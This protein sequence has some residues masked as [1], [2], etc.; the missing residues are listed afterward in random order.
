MEQGLQQSFGSNCF[1]FL[2]TFR[3]RAPADGIFLQLVVLARSALWVYQSFV[4]KNSCL[5]LLDTQLIR[6]SRL[7]KNNAVVGLKKN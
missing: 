1:L 5:L 3:T 6:M 4:T 7:N 2:V